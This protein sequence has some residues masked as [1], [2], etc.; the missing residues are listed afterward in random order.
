MNS[1]KFM[2][3]PIFESVDFIVLVLNEKGKIEYINNFGAGLFKRNKDDMIGMDWFQFI[4]ENRKDEIKIVFESV[5][6]GEPEYKYYENPVILD[7]GKE[8][9]VLWHNS[10]IKVNEK[11][12]IISLGFLIDPKIR[13]VH[14][15]RIE[16]EKFNNF[17]QS[18]RTIGH[19]LNNLFTSIMGNLSLLKMSIK[20]KED[21]E[22]LKDIEIALN[23]ALEIAR[24]TLNFSKIESLKKEDFCIND[25]LM[26]TAKFTLIG[27]K[28][29]VS[30][31][32]EE[33]K[34]NVTGDPVKISE[35]IQNIILNAL[36][37]MNNCGELIVRLKRIYF[38]EYHPFLKKGEYALISIKDNGTGIPPEL[39]DKIFL[40]FFTTK[41]G[42][43]G[44][45]LSISLKLMKEMGGFIDFIS[46]E[47]EGSEF[48]I[49]IPLS[50]KIII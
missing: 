4:P 11:I 45:G 50:K 28:T 21:I 3:D 12:Y 35:V 48:F 8:K 19:E 42:G 46:K 7:D 26:E 30:Y 47:K 14:Q 5:K 18:L 17:S 44:L 43:S 13:I 22:I 6:N 24:R 41:K 1:L 23:K 39:R 15:N 16:I 2:T 27:K 29:K 33:E 36:E 25:L 20:E 9:K 49:Y 40:P 38:D 10:I 34:I 31:E 32:I 37:S